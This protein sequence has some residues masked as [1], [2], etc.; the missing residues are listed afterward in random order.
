MIRLAVWSPR[1]MSGGV[2][3]SRTPRNG[4]PLARAQVTTS[5]VST[6]TGS[7]PF[8]GTTRSAIVITGRATHSAAK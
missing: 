7:E 3:I 1:P 2:T 4:T 8:G 6:V 5:R